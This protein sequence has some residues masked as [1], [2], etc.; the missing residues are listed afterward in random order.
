[1]YPHGGA[2]V[3]TDV[4]VRA[5]TPK[6]NGKEK[7]YFDRDGLYLSVKSTKSGVGKYWRLKYRY[8][9]KEKLLALGVFPKVS[10]KA[11]RLKCSDARRLLDE[12]R[13]PSQLKKAAK[14]KISL[15]QLNS[16]RVVADEWYSKQLATWADSTAKKRRALLDNDL[17]PWLGDR[18]IDD[19]DAAELLETLRRIENRGAKETA[20]NARQ[21]AGQIFRYARATQRTKNDPAQDLKGA[22]AP[23]T[24]IHRPAIL[25]P[26]DFGKL[27]RAID[28]Y[29]GSHIVRCLLRLCPLLFQRPGE[30]ISMRWVDLD[31]ES[32]QW[33]LPAE[34]M[35]SRIAHTVPLS[36]QSLAVLMDIKPL[37]GHGEFVFP[38]QRR[39]GKHASPGTINKALQ[40][41][42]YDTKLVMCAHGFRASART[43]LDEVLGINAAWIEHQLAHQ[44]SDRL[45]RAYNRTKHLPQR[46]KMMQEWAD[47]LDLL[48]ESADV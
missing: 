38:S 42:G 30:M 1:M 45:G 21:V 41:M 48:R 28:R 33:N 23:K 25:E 40:G 12:G 47:Y 2:L 44:P 37:T 39:Q 34:T 31:L 13:D 3:L 17:Y 24:P 11:A 43:M 19:I 35:K 4:E 27:I 9:A 46:Q 6:E 8:A 29:S 36:R 20:H 10:L 14:A 5:A 7:R 22:L 32:A 15:S 16:F 26:K 18:P